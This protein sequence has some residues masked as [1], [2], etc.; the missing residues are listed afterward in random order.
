MAKLK[1]MTVK[2]IEDYIINSSPIFG[3]PSFKDILRIHVNGSYYKVFTRI[4]EDS[5]KELD[6]K[7]PLFI[8]STININSNGEYEFEDNLEAVVSGILDIK[9]LT[10][11]PTSIVNLEG[12][13]LNC[14]RTFIYDEGTGTLRASSAT[15]LVECDYLARHP[16]FHEK[17]PTEDE[18]TDES[19]IYGVQMNADY[20]SDMFIN[21]VI[22][23]LVCYIIELRTQVNYTELPIEIFSG[24]QDKKSDMDRIVEEFLLAPVQYY[25]LWR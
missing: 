17:H 11:H 21:L 7:R 20:V 8:H 19:V 13:L 3:M 5:L 24:C 9:Y 16:F 10:L 14:A 23:H 22:Y 12:S 18:F 1:K 25:D 2:E 15:G 4:L 6:R